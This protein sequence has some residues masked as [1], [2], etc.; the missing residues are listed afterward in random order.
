MPTDDSKTEKLFIG[1]G[2]DQ[3]EFSKIEPISID[4]E[5][6]RT[7]QWLSDSNHKEEK[8]F[9]FDVGIDKKESIELF[10]QLIQEGTGRMELE[11]SC[12]CDGTY[13]FAV[14]LMQALQRMGAT[15]IKFHSEILENPDPFWMS[16]RFVST[17]IVWNTNNFRRMHGIPMKRRHRT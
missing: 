4:S 13:I 1:N 2:D 7:P 11:A 3:K 16:C 17:G 10:N 6:V 15:N 12:V 14:W 9:E 8:E 5:D